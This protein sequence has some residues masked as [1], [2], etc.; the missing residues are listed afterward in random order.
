LAVETVDFGGEAVA[1]FFEILCER[2][3][4]Q[5]VAEVREAKTNG[6][7]RWVLAERKRDVA[8]GGKGQR[9]KECE[10]APDCLPRNSTAL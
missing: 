9:R 8:G 1:G 6:R 7:E 3:E 5:Q 4:G 2:G 10:N